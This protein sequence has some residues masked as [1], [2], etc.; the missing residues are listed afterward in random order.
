MRILLDEC[1]PERLKDELPDHDVR[2][3]R[4]AGLAGKKNGILLDLA[5]AQFEVLV[6]IDQNL[7][8]QQHLE[9]KLGVVIVRA[10]SNSF[11]ALAPLMPALRQALSAITPG[12]V[13]RV[14]P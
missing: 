3:A 5:S 6:T 11:A 2:T 8:D 10:R 9:G 7:P 13:L 4:E 14:G 12:Q 1:L